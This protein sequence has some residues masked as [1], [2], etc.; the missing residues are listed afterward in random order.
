MKKGKLTVIE[1]ACIKGMIAQDISIQDMCLQL[2]RSDHVV[3]KEVETLKSEAVR[4]QLYIN[5]TATGSKGV[6]IMTEAASVRGDVT[7][8]RVTTI[9]KKDTSSPWVHKIHN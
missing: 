6:S 3:G 7:K 1:S 4:E 9:P 2:D 8:D 5:K